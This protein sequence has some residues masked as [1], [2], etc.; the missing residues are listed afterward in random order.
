[1]EASLL[2]FK[3][4]RTAHVYTLGQL[5]E[6]TKDIWIVCHGYG[7]LASRIIKKFNQ[8]NLDNTYV[9]APE[10]LSKFYYKRKPL[11]IGSSW[12]TRENREDEIDDYIQYINSVY[13]SLPSSGSWRLNVLGFSQG[14]STMMRWLDSRRPELYKVIMWAGEFPHDIAYASFKEY[15][16]SASNRFFCVGDTDEFITPERVEGLHAFLVQHELDIEIKQ[17]S[18]KHEIDRCVLSEVFLE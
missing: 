15:F 17:F 3:I 6:E 7:Q 8:L 2:K 9:M 18:G 16:N 4:E 10:G 1:M 14:C 11:I 5:N 13:D 12:M